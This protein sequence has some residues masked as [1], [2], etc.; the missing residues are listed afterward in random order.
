M[1]RDAPD[2]SR[3]PN[4]PVQRRRPRRHNADTS[5]SGLKPLGDRSLAD[6]TG[7]PT[8]VLLAAATDS[9][10][11]LTQRAQAV[12]RE[13]G[14]FARCEAEVDVERLG[15]VLRAGMLVALTGIGTVFSGSWIVWSVRHRLSREAHEMTVTLLRN[16]VGGAPSGGA[17]GLAGMI[18]AL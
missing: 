16:A 15:V 14:W 7:K 12:L 18:G 2:S 17:G 4:R 5:N 10:G 1:G 3:R 8:S 9:A 11:E 13:A 6:F